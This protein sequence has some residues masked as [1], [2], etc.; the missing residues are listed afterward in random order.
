[1]ARHSHTGWL[2]IVLF[3]LM[4]STGFAQSPKRTISDD[5]GIDQ[6]LGEQVPLDLEFVDEAGKKVK[7]REFFTDKPVILT[8]VYYRCPMLC[9]QVL[10]GVL[11]SAQGLTLELDEDYTVLS[12]SI[13]PRETPKNA[14][15][16]KQTYIRQYRRDGA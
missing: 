5:I 11:K 3:V 8:C 1:Y 7:L 13:D 15:E 12:I 2:A 4:T 10:N 16:K 14:A 6:R 9:T